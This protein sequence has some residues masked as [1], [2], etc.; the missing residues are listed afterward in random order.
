MSE[1]K[2]PP[3]FMGEETKACPAIVLRGGDRSLFPFSQMREQDHFADIR[4]IREQHG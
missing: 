4:R 3:L 1:K 2:S